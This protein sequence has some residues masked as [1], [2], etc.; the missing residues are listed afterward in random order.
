MNGHF[1]LSLDFEKHWGV[2][3][4]RTV[5]SYKTNLENVKPVIRNL[6]ELADKYGVKLTFST[7]GFLFAE[8]KEELLK[9]TPKNKPTY[10]KKIRSPYNQFSTIGE[11]ELDDPFHY[12]MSSINEIKDNGN[13]EIG[14]H[15]F[16]HYYCH[17]KGQ[18]VKQFEDDLMA[19]IAIAK[20]KGI[21]TK[22]IVFPRNMISANQTTDKPYLDVCHKHQITSFRGKEKAFFYNVR[23]E[24]FYKNWYIFKILRLTDSYFNITGHNTYKVES[25]YKNNTPLNLPS[26]RFLRPY[27]KTLGFLEH[28][29]I[30][31]IKKAM[32][33]A[34][35]HNEMFHLW[36]HPHNFGAN[37]NKNFSNLEI[38][39]KAYKALNLKNGFNSETMT[40]LTNK[41]VSKHQNS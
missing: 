2:F 27:S 38:I 29:K 28:L 22:S 11:N 30:R 5:E 14:T 7:V 9:F 36:F 35:K 10:S 41:V 8:N 40:G 26:S 37:K 31:R 23:T 25:Y 12:A 4:K 19:S 21:T 13:H 16:S 34:A 24:K 3:D 18:T 20:S 17:E 15:T 33:H 6:L 39:F 1:V 32:K